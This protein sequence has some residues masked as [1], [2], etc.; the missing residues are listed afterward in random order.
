MT[1]VPQI[2]TEL[3]REYGGLARKTLFEFIPDHE[4]RRYLYD[5][6]GNY[7][8]RGGRGMRPALHIAAARAFGASLE[9]ALSTATSI[10]LFHNALLVLDDIQDESDERRGQPTLHKVHGVPLAMNAGQATSILSLIPLLGN[11][12]TNGSEM[13]LWIIEAV[14]NMAQI[15]AEGQA[16]ELGWRRDNRVDVTV[17]DYLDMVL[18]K[19]CA[20]STLFPIR[21]GAMIGLR[22]RDVA[23]AIERYAFLLGA[24]FQIQDDLLNIAGPSAS[25]GKEA[26][27]DLLEGKRTLITIRLFEQATE[28]ERAFLRQFL[29]QDRQSKTEDEL[30]TVLELIRRHDVVEY[31]RHIV[32][33]MVG[34][35]QYEFERGFAGLSPSRDLELLRHMPIWIIEQS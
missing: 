23:P 10:E 20:Y 29:A 12:S 22:Q 35:A 18:R 4:P 15:T 5:L 13:A 2:V 28:P 9:Q 19:T 1:R 3:L 6:I 11:V 34:A 31:V 26:Y 27:G 8:R 25:Y 24:A 33:A 30:R 17:R 7:P 21:M 14:F 16:C 32:Q